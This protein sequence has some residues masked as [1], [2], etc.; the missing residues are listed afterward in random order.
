MNIYSDKLTK[1]DLH[2]A[3]AAVPGLMF[4]EFSDLERPRVREHGWNVQL[5]RRGSRLPFVQM[6]R[7]SVAAANG[8][9][10]ASRDDWGFFLAALYRIDVKMQV[11]SKYKGSG[12]FHAQT[13]NAYRPKRVRKS[14]AQYRAERKQKET[15]AA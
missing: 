14:G 2:E 3:L 4:R 7:G 15:V 8:I 6:T 12:D 11:A 13:A 10:A 5:Q 1:S 9:G